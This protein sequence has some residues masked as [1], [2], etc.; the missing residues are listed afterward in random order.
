MK[1][2]VILATSIAL[3]LG[4]STIAHGE[5]NYNVSRIEGANRYKTSS[6]ISKQFSNDKV[7]NVIIASGRNFPDAL[8]GSSLSKKLNAPILLVD[9]DV[10]DSLDSIDYIKN[11]LNVNGNVYILGGNASVSENYINYIKSLGYKNIIRLGGK[12][13]FDTNRAIINS[14]NIKK[15]TPIVI[16]NG[17]GFADALSVSS[18]AASKGYPILMS[19]SKTLPDEIKAKIREIQPSKLYLIGGQGSLSNNIVTEVRNIVPSLNYSNITRVWGNSRYDTSLEICKYFN[20][21]SD[22]AVIANGEN[23]PDALSGSALAA[24]QNAP[25]ILT[26][27]KDMLNQKKIFKYNKL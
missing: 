21:D 8:A 6:N 27:G 12:N 18:A 4:T 5:N 3:I 24:K 19:D 23:F 22:T 20:L 11:H 25:I 9:K 26:N 10:K 7:N 14:M 1:K 17:Y 16:T 13:R 2:V 15:R